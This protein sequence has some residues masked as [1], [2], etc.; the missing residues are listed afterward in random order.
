MCHL[1]LGISE[2]EFIRFQIGL[3]ALFM[4]MEEENGQEENNQ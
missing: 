4:M 3:E 1:C 2:R